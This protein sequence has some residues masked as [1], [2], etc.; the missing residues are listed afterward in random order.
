[1]FAFLHGRISYKKPCIWKDAVTHAYGI[2]LVSD[3]FKFKK[4]QQP[5][6]SMTLKLEEP[7]T[8][9]LCGTEVRDITIPPPPQQVQS[10]LRQQGVGKHALRKEQTKAEILWALKCVMSHFSFNSTADITDIFGAMF[11][12]SAIAQKMSCGPNKMSYLICFGIAQY[13]RQLLLAEL[14]ETPCFVISFDESLNHGLKKE[15]MDFV[16]RYFKKDKVVCTSTFLGHT[17][18]D[19]LKK[20]FEEGTQHLDMKNMVQISMD[21]PIVNHK[22]YDIITEERKENDHP[23]LINVGSCSLHVV[24]G[25]FHTGEKKTN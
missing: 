8:S 18:V 16:V 4:D 23:E 13:F 17:H 20:K 22:L 3:F 15:Q 2:G 6:M 25:A 9:L 19:D 21:G 7:S 14:K 12:D 24:P 10:R 11:P 1:M 5:E